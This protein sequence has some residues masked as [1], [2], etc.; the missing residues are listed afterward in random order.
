MSAPAY[1]LLLDTTTGDLAMAYGDLVISSGTDAVLQA[2]RQRLNFFKGEWFADESIGMPWFQSILVKGA[3]L[4]AIRELFRKEI[5][6][7]PGVA[8]VTT[9]TIDY[10]G[11][12]RTMTL[13]FVAV[14]DSGA[15]LVADGWQ[16]GV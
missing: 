12:T 4:T 8:S 5:L 16:L 2:I 14:A 15:Q 9:I 3:D 13:D 6:A 1:D 11:T 7:T 10:V